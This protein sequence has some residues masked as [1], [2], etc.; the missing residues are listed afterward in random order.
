MQ[1]CSLEDMF[2][3]EERGFARA[4]NMTHQLQIV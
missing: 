2:S 3:I 4:I 1:I